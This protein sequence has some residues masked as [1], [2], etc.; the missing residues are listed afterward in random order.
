MKI[1]ILGSATVGM[2]LACGLAA[3][4]HDVFIANSRGPESLVTRLAQTG[5]AAKPA[6]V[7]EA[8]ACDVIFLAV[9]WLKVPEVLKPD[10]S[11]EG[12]ILV[13]TTNIFVSYAPDFRVDDLRGDSGSE[14]VARLAP[15]ARVVKAFNTLPFTVM[16]APTPAGMKRVLF[17]AGD[18]S[19]AVSTVASLIEE[20]GFHPVALGRLAGAGRQME[21]GGPLSSLELLLP[22]KTGTS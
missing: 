11:W 2:T 22:A 13:D 9:P 10:I 20:L 6:S 3:V 16:F 21:L 4:G 18:E 7:S 1:G 19:E 17:V 8:L 15:S 12:R 5:T 14:S